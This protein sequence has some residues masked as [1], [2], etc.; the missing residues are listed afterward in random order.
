M[1]LS[2]RDVHTRASPPSSMQ[3]KLGLRNVR[4]SGDLIEYRSI[5]LR[6]LP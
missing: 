1:S 5:P 6:S 4:S 3:S 2:S